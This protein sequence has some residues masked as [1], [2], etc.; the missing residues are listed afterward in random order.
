LQQVNPINSDFSQRTDALA[1]AL[2]IPLND[3]ADVIGISR[4]MLMGYRTGRHIPSHKAL[5]KLRAAEERA[6]TKSDFK[7][8]KSD[9]LQESADVDWRDRALQ[10]EKKSED[11]RRILQTLL[12]SRE[13]NSH[14]DQESI[15]TE[16]VQAPRKSVSYRDRKP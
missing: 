9:R 11:L 14:K 16:D 13:D 15:R 4:D 2:G 12:D 1:V 7:S 6:E 10:A 8:E 5:M 3:L